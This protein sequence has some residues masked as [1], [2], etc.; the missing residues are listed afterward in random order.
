MA[1]EEGLEPTTLRLT[2]QHTV[3]LDSMYCAV[4]CCPVFSSP[5]QRVRPVLNCYGA[6]WGFRDPVVTPLSMNGSSSALTTG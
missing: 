5:A 1:P 4:E 6:C 2:A 3:I